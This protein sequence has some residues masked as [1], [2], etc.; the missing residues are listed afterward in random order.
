VPEQLALQHPTAFEP[1]TSGASASSPDSTTGDAP[2]SATSLGLGL[3]LVARIAKAHGGSL[4]ASNRPEGGARI[5][6][7]LGIG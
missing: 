3:S 6:L 2:T 4:T 5:V 1:F 7:E